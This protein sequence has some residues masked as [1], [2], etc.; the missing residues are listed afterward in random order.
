[1]KQFDPHTCASEKLLADNL[2]RITESVEQEMVEEETAAEKAAAEKE[3]L[4][5][6]VSVE[7][8]TPRPIERTAPLDFDAARIANAVRPTDIE[9]ITAVAAHFSVSK[10][11]A[12][13]WICDMANT[14]SI[15]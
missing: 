8:A 10:Q 4:L 12:V 9:I 6:K 14:V 13:D 1:M 3:E 5:A 15:V 7:N 11:I 2:K